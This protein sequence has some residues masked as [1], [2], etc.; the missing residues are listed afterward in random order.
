MP[1][2]KDCSHN[3]N[4]NWKV[5]YMKNA[6]RRKVMDH[7]YN[8]SKFLYIIRIFYIKVTDVYRFV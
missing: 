1:E 5:T 8:V 6:L 7:I 4:K 3:A 2:W